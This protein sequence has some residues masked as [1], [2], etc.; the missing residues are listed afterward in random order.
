MDSGT[1][2]SKTPQCLCGL[3]KCLEDSFRLVKLKEEIKTF[4]LKCK[5]LEKQVHEMLMMTGVCVSSPS[6]RE[7]WSSHTMCSNTTI[8]YYSLASLLVLLSHHHSLV[9][10][11]S[12]VMWSLQP[13]LSHSSHDLEESSA[14][15]A[16]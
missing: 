15:T 9:G 11:V 6:D 4:K 8:R 13:P 1:T 2:S 5:E 7:I 12:C 10:V 16:E 3:H 14:H